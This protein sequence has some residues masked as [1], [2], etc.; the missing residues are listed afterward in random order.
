MLWGRLASDLRRGSE[1]PPGRHAKNKDEAGLKEERAFA[2]ILWESL[3][4]G[5]AGWYHFLL[6]LDPARVSGGQRKLFES[7]IAV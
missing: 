3:D 2:E 4:I 6:P 7:Y 5:R 1:L